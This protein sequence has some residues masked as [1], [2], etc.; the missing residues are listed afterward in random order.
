MQSCLIITGEKSGEEH[1]MSFFSELKKHSPETHFYGVGGDELSG[2]GLE[3]LYHLNDFSSWGYSG[4]ITKIPF[5]LKAMDRILRVVQ[6]RQTKVAILVD[7]QSFNLKLAGKLKKQGV[8]VLYYVAPQ[9]WAWKEYRVKK[10]SQCVHTLFTII[11]FEKKWFQERGVK[12][13]ISIDHPLWTTYQKEL[14]TFNSKE[15]SRP[16]RLLLLPGSRQFEVETLLPPFI[17]AIKELKKEFP[18]KVSIV[19]SSS[20]RQN[21]FD[22]FEHLF[23]KVYG[24]DELVLA[25]KEADFSF[26]ASGTVTLTCALFEVPTIVCYKTSLLNQ[27]I[28][29]V[30]VKYRGH[31]SLANIIQNSTVFPELLQDQVTAYNIVSHFKF[32]YY[33]KEKSRVL[34]EQLKE[35]KQLVRGEGKNIPEYM[36]SVIKNSYG[37]K[38]DTTS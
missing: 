6:E 27:F 28:Y 31:I 25:L 2:A 35:T 15:L 22:S 11:P 8:E 36:A 24:N 34:K 9:A 32:W 14:E 29:E 21:L 26:A 5:Y 13:V 3:L 20:I 33:N 4:V 30:F 38:P 18:L 37:K 23:E 10:L 1:A 7:Y 16:I 19:K 12:R 17:E